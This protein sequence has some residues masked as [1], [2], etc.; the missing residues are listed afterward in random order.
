[1]HGW[2]VAQPPRKSSESSIN[3]ITLH[4]PQGLVAVGLRYRSMLAT[5]VAVYG[6]SCFSFPLLRCMVTEQMDEDEGLNN[7]STG[8][9]TDPKNPMEKWEF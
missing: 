7:W 5:I 3:T 8:M 1:M 4:T 6:A 9:G 2:F